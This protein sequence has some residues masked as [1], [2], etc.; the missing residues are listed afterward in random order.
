MKKICFISSSRADYGLIK[1][2]MRRVLETEGLTLQLALTGAHLDDRYGHTADMVEKDG[3][4]I[5]AR[6][7]LVM[8]DDSPVGVAAT[9]ASATAG[10]GKALDQLKPDLL[11]VLGDRHEMLAA[12]LA[13]HVARIP[14]AHHS[15][16]DVT[17]GAYDD[18]MR[19][20][21]TKCADFHFVS[22]EASHR[23]VI[24]MGENPD[25]VFLVGGLGI[26][27]IHT[28]EL[29]TKEAL[30]EDLGFHFGASS[31]LITFHPETNTELR[32]LDQ[33]NNLL[34]ALGS[35]TDTG[36]IF[37]APNHD[38]GTFEIYSAI[39]K[40]VS[41]KDNSILVTSLGEKRYLSAAKYVGG[42]V[43]NSS[44]GIC[45]I[46]SLQKPVL[47]IGDRQNGRER[48]SCII[49][50][51]NNSADIEKGLKTLLSAEFKA[52]ALTTTNPYDHGIASLNVMQNLLDI[53]NKATGSKKF[54][55]LSSVDI[56]HH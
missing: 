46:P 43:G 2:V 16:G 22:C 7:P 49:D 31:L 53:S 21:I 29:M 40:F 38:M 44:S 30:E 19:H 1:N 35:L 17:T 5:D 23:R 28:K 8:D 37:T 56:G 20:C 39:E 11:F 24:Q 48:A 47:N 14:I 25:N 4:V 32:P 13:A 42:V 52:Q 41:E 12:V 55:E 18:A 9:M 36:M 54:H 45:E 6:V 3:F 10:F 33:I 15:G 27:N 51:A 34:S 26:E 50:V